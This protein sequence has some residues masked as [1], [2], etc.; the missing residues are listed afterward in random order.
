[1]IRILLNKHLYSELINIIFSYA[2]PESTSLNKQIKAGNYTYVHK[3]LQNIGLLRPELYDSYIGA[4]VESDSVSILSL[5]FTHLPY[6]LDLFK[7][8]FIYARAFDSEKY[9]ICIYIHNKFAKTQHTIKYDTIEQRRYLENS[10]QKYTKIFINPR[11][12]IFFL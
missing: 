11:W 5:L 8:T 3:Y 12:I 6:Q 4:A 2:W 1:M 7:A 9:N 10:Q